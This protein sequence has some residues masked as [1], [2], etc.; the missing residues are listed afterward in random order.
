MATL[1]TKMGKDSATPNIETNGVDS[2]IDDHVEAK[3]R[4]KEHYTQA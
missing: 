3:G 4:K 1:L 2:E